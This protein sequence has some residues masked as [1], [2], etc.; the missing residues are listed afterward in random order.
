MLKLEQLQPGA[1][2]RG[3]VPDAMVIVVSVQW[4]GSEALISSFLG[5]FLSEWSCRRQNCQHR[6][7]N[8]TST[9]RWVVFDQKVAPLL[10]QLPWSHD[11]L[12]MSR[13]D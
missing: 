12:M 1:A 3:I 9:Q 13:C 10:R 4:F 11:L 2:V 7:Q 8:Y 5:I 6:W